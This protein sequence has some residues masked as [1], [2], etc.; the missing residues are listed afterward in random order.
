MKLFKDSSK[1]HLLITGSKGI[2]KSTLLKEIL[3]DY[4]NYGGITTDLVISED[5]LHKIVVLKDI[6]DKDINANVGERFHNKM[7]PILKGFEDMGVRILNKYR[8]SNKELIVI[9]EIGFLEV[10]AERYQG[11][12]FLCFRD[13]RVIA[14]L[15][16]EDNLLIN[17]IK[18][19]EGTF[20]I[21]LDEFVCK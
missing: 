12:I 1:K 21:D 19:I 18:E 16:K 10:G 17:K 4:D 15:R 6:L 8:N 9:D 14:I 3:K 5:S 13:K 11:E 2:G 20:L 7:K